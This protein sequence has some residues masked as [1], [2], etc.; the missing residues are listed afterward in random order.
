MTVRVPLVK[1][2]LGEEKPGYNTEILTV[3][4]SEC[5]DWRMPF[6]MQ[7]LIV[8]ISQK[9]RNIVVNTKG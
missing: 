5:S 3:D 2:K 6:S 1:Q 7:K 9:S 8:Q 4:H